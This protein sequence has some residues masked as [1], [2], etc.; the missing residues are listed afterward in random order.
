V[1]GR[2]VTAKGGTA[3]TQFQIGYMGRWNATYMPVGTDRQAHS[4][5]E[6]HFSLSQIEPPQ[7][8][9]KIT[10]FAFA[11]GYA[12]GWAFVELV[13]GAMVEEVVIRLKPGPVV[14]GVVVD[15][16]GNPVPNAAL[17]VGRVA[18]SNDMHGV[19]TFA[20][21][22]S[23]SSGR[24]RLDQLSPSVSFLHVV[25]LPEYA[26]AKF[27]IAFSHATESKEVKV[28]L[29]SGASIDGKIHRNGQ[30]MEGMRVNIGRNGSRTETD[31][32]GQFFADMLT[33]GEVELSGHYDGEDGGEIL[34]FKR[35]VQLSDGR[36]TA[37]DIDLSDGDGVVEGT[38]SYGGQPVVWLD[39]YQGILGGYVRIQFHYPDGTT[40][41]LQAEFSDNGVFRFEGI[42]HGTAEFLV[43]YMD[44]SGFR[45]KD[46]GEF[47]ITGPTPIIRDFELKGA[48]VL[49]G[50]VVGTATGE[51]HILLLSGDMRMPED[52]L[53]RAYGLD[54]EARYSFSV[55][56]Q[57][58]FRFQGFVPGLY[59]LVTY[60]QDLGIQTQML[61]EVPITGEAQVVV[62]LE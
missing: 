24:F 43:G 29:T 41:Q 57:G 9:K 11:A 53:R 7:W 15:A 51:A 16:R 54:S 8:G 61:V 22:L 10:V 12:P 47:E 13:P 14:E 42:P 37:V 23:D 3:I 62:E 58:A 27:P 32:A 5:K 55:E 50:E 60:T 45:V 56:P 4:N 35:L 1:E 19:R 2:V 6:G 59:T 20:D 38:V 46:R 39:M 31:E 25:A 30:P 28:V 40:K 17:Y 52:E 26:P 48:G 21:T 33:P 36:S 49:A 18:S 34:N 44:E